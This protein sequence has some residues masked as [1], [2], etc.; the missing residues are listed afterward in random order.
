MRK[1]LLIALSFRSNRNL[2]PIPKHVP[3]EVCNSIGPSNVQ[4]RGWSYAASVPSETPNAQKGGKR[5]PRHE[6]RAMVESFVNKYRA[7]NAGKFPTTKDIKKQVGG[8]YYVVREISQ[9]LKYNSKMK[10]SNGMDEIL[11]EK[12]FDDSKLLTTESV[13]VSSGN[14]EIAKHRPIQ[15][16]SPSVVL[17]DKETVDTGY[18]HLEEKGGP[19]T[20]SWERKLSNEYETISTPGNNYIA[21]ESNVL[22]KCSKEPYQSSL[23][24]PN[25]VKAEEALSSYSDSVA[26]ESQLLQEEIEGVSTP[27]SASYGTDYGKARAY[28]S[29]FVDA[30]NHQNMEKKCIEKTGYERRE[31]PALEDL[32]GELSHS[33]L[34][35][36]NDVRNGEAVSSCSSDSV[37]PERHLIKEE[38]EQVSAPFIEKS[39]RSIGQSHDSKFVDMENHQTTEKKGF[40]KAAYE[41]KEQDA[42]EDLPGV[43]GSKHKM[44]QSQGS[45]E[46]DESKIDS[47]ISRE[48]SVAVISEKSTFWGNLKSFADSI[49]NIWRK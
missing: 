31:Q 15:D 7:E 18:D 21:S 8:S 45:L 28:E 23:Q 43:D 33:S 36:P 12:L 32:S 39:G 17:D 47:S 20:S 42:L 44:E 24:M 41:I 35:V 34:Q 9:E 48:T 22:D 19:R 46:L 11:V 6:R 5:V 37:A 2:T 14:T 38:I 25:D 16:V 10:S 29:E 4:W 49:I 40:E 3:F 27:F 13:N 30:E 26:P 1:K